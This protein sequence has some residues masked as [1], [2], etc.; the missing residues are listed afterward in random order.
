MHVAFVGRI[1]TWSRCSRMIGPLMI[2]RV[3][4]FEGDFIEGTGRIEASAGRIRVHEMSPGLDGSVLLRYH[5]VPYLTTSPPVAAQS[6]SVA[7]TIRSSLSV[8]DQLPE[9]ALSSSSSVSPLVISHRDFGR[10]SRA[11]QTKHAS[12]WCERGFLQGRGMPCQRSTPEQTNP[13]E[14][15]G[16]RTGSSGA[17]GH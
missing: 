10:R 9:P 17:S 11:G 1:L 6:R 7:K 5:S 2:G 4:G 3:M 15:I 13:V 14:S 16:Y 12:G 8:C